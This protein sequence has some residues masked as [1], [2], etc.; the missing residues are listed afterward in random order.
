MSTRGGRPFCGGTLLSSDTVLTAAHC[1]TS[2]SSFN[3]VVGDHDVS[4]GDGE[5]R[6]RPRYRQHHRLLVLHLFPSQWISHPNYRGNDNDFA[7]IKLSSPVTIS[8][9]VLPACLPTSNKNYDGCKFISLL[10]MYKLSLS[11][12]WPQSLDGELC[13]LVEA[14]QTFFRR[15]NCHEYWHEM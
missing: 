8:D 5:Q 2:V 12:L 4:R 13:P 11:G 15:Y 10:M 6:Y 1:K 3:V 9:T 14:S 7:I